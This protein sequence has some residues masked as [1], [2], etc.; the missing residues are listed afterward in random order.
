MGLR[1]KEIESVKGKA[2]NYYNCK[3]VKEVILEDLEDFENLSDAILKEL[4]FNSRAFAN[5]N[6]LLTVAKKIKKRRFGN[7]EK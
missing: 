5:I 4:D 1:D 2:Y 3:I 6:T 7:F